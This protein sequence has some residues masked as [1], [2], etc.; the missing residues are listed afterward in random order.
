MSADTEQ[1][2]RDIAEYLGWK[3]NKRGYYYVTDMDI[4][5]R[6]S[7]N[8]CPD[9]LVFDKDWAILMPVWKKLKEELLESYCEANVVMIRRIQQA[10]ANRC[11]IELSHKLIHEAIK[12]VK[13]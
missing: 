12:L 13:K 8:Y 10:I 6:I 9:G 3:W 1:M 5:Y 4:F 2:N 7:P 11:D